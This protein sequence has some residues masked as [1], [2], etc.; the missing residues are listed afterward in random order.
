[1]RRAQCLLF[2]TATILLDNSSV[3][4]S[5]AQSQTQ[6]QSTTAE[7]KHHLSNKAQLIYVIDIPVVISVA[8]DFVTLLT[9]VT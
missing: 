8:A 1:M 4:N 9:L 6:C 5:E 3:A 2:F 7:F